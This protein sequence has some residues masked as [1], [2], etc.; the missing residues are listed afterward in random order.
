IPTKLLEKPGADPSPARRL[1]EGT[2]EVIS[3]SLYPQSPAGSTPVGL[4]VSPDG[5]TLF[6][7]NADNNSVVV[8]DISNTIS[9]EAR[10]NRESVSVIEGFIPVGWYPSALAVSPDNGTLFVA[11]GKGLRSRPNVPAKSNRP[12]PALPIRF[13]HVGKT[14]EGSVSFIPKPDTAQM[15]AYTEQV[16]RNSPYPPDTLRRTAMKS[17]GAIPDVV[18]Q[19]CPIK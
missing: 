4:A 2:R 19:P 7:A 15:V 18:G 10:K 16:R 13:D 12:R 9:E 3:T 6:V 1:W 5:K 14:L 8:I 17:D 11:N